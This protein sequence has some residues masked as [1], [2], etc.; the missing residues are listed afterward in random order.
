MC[1][2]YMHVLHVVV[3]FQAQ[4]LYLKEMNF[5]YLN[6]FKTCSRSIYRTITKQKVINIQSDIFW[7]MFSA[8][9]DELATSLTVNERH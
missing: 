3:E 9:G 2:L 6:K 8:I 1:V 4:K 7:I 5:N